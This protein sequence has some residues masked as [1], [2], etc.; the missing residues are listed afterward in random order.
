MTV[1]LPGSSAILQKVFMRLQTEPG[2]FDGS[3]RL[4]AQYVAYR[5]SQMHLDS[6][7]SY[8]PLIHFPGEG[9]LISVPYSS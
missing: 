8:L 6:K 2:D 3:Y 9:Q 4:V 1:R 5:K 7:R